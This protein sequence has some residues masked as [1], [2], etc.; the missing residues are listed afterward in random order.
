[1][2]FGREWTKF[3][4]RFKEVSGLESV[5]LERVDST[6]NTSP[7]VKSLT[8]QLSALL[9]VHGYCLLI[10]CG[11]Q[12]WY[13]TVHQG[14]TATAVRI[15]SSDHKSAEQ[16]PRDHMRIYSNKRCGAQSL[17]SWFGDAIH[18]KLNLFHFTYCKNS[19]EAASR[20]SIEVYIFWTE[21]PSSIQWKIHRVS[22]Q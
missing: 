12:H 1:M 13:G 7:C 2:Q 17:F 20:K 19:R 15:N 8:G 10:L 16:N 14:R 5:R 4:V 22:C 21:K 6:C 9:C 18:L 3:A 11:L